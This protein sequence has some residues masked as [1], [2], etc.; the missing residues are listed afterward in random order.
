M[1]EQPGTISETWAQ[2]ATWRFR[3]QVYNPRT[4]LFADLSDWQDFWCTFKTSHD[5]ADEG[6]LFQLSFPTDI[7]LVVGDP[8]TIE[9]TIPAS[10]TT[11]AAWLGR[12]TR[13]YLDVKGR[14]GDG[15]PWLLA[16]G[17]GTVLASGTRTG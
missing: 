9:I 6:A 8:T 3:V 13:G 2:G 11:G 16:R 7:A 5:D 1:S 14:D 17:R 12:T 4:S 15:L 10:A